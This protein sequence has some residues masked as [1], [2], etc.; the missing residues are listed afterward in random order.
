MDAV[1]NARA[2]V[3]AVLAE[4]LLDDLDREELAALVSACGREVEVSDRE[5]HAPGEVGT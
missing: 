2:Q 5:P 3:V 1:A 4:L